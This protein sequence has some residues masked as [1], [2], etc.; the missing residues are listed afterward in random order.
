MATALCAAG[1]AAEEAEARA[2]LELILAVDASGSV[3]NR[4][5]GLQLGGIADAFRTR[6]IQSAAASGPEGR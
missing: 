2:D 4:E 3:N 6:E 1:A 5:F